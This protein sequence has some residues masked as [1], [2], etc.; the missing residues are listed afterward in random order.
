MQI[1]E[2]EIRNVHD[3]RGSTIQHV[4]FHDDQIEIYTPENKVY[5][6][7]NQIFIRL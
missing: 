1:V 4:I 5:V 2:A 3:L 6:F 7:N